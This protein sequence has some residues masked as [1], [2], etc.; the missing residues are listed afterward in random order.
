MSQAAYLLKTNTTTGDLYAYK[1]VSGASFY[2]QFYIKATAEG[3][4]DTESVWTVR[5]VSSTLSLSSVGIQIVQSGANLRFQMLHHIAAGWQT[6]I[7]GTNIALDTWYG[8]RL[9]VNDGAGAT[10]T[11]QWWVD[12]SNDGSWTDEGSATSV[13]LDRAIANA[14]IGPAGVTYTFAYYITG[15]KIDDDAMPAGCAR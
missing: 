1:G 8:V 15:I 3:L 4:A 12:Y 10:D 6:D 14:A 7:G 11:V 2:L 9:Y 13:E 5:L